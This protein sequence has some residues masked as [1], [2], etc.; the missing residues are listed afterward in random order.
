[1]LSRLCVRSARDKITVKEW[2]GEG[3]RT[4]EKNDNLEDRRVSAKSNENKYY[5]L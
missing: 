5:S 4:Q 3:R 2:A 1:M